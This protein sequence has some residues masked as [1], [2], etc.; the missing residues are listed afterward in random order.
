MKVDQNRLVTPHLFTTRGAPCW[1]SESLQLLEISANMTN[2]YLEHVLY[3]SDNYKMQ[4]QDAKN[5]CLVSAEWNLGG[6]CLCV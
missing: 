1:P 4:L 5:E 3:D 2:V 6:F